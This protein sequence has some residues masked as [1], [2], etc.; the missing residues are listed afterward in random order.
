[1]KKYK[2][3][4]GKR[5]ITVYVTEFVHKRLHSITTEKNISYTDYL[6]EAL[7]TKLN[8]DDKEDDKILLEKLSKRIEELKQ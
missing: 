6:E 8:M 5:P 4:N 7:V 2:L 1:M 3:K